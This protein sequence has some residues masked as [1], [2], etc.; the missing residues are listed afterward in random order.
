MLFNGIEGGKGRCSSLHT[1]EYEGVS[2]SIELGFSL[3]QMVCKET[4][5][6]RPIYNIY[7][8][9]FPGLVLGIALEGCAAAT[10]L[11]L[12]SGLQKLV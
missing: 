10:R 11:Y 7:S 5:Q 4:L 1:L 9:S 8:F 12:G 3:L 2:P 6:T